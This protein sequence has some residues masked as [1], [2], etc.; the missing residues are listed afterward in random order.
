MRLQVLHPSFL[1]KQDHKAASVFCLPQKIQAA[2]AIFG[3]DV[4]FGSD[5]TQKNLL[6]IISN[7]NSVAGNWIGRLTVGAKNKTFIMGTYGGICVLGAHAWTNAQQGTGAA[8]EPVYINPDGDKA[9]YIGGS[10]I[11][12]KQALMVLQNVNANT[13]GTVKINRST[14][15]SN[16]F[17]DVAC[18]GDNISKFNNDSGF[19]TSISYS[20]VINA[21]GYTPYD[22]SNPSGY[23]ANVIETVKVNGTELTP[24]NK[25]VDITV[26][27]VNNP[28]ITITQGGVTKGSF[29]LNQ[30]T[31]D[32]IALDAGGASAVTSVNGRTG[33]VTGLEETSNKVTSVSSA[34]TNDQ[35]P[36]AK[37][38]YDI[39]QD[40]Q[41]MG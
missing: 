20:D 39:I 6:A 31:G 37:C 23:Q 5:T 29:T 26:P 11:N 25:A 9:V 17:K 27:T 14:N 38:L 32:T 2:K 16:N 19:I 10:P 40:F 7:S 8:W 36:T 13:T 35:Y 18:W 21:L 24:S 4:A 33:A 28:T 41:W 22:S 15:L 34:S 3:T 12:G 1:K 30:S